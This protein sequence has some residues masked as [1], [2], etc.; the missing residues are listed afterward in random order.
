MCPTK[1]AWDLYNACKNIE[2]IMIDEAGHSMLEE[3]I[4][5]TLIK[6]TEGLISL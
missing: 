6:K 3:G 4:Q 1:S 2:L 5:K